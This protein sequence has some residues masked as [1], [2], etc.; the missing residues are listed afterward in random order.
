[1]DRHTTRSAGLG[2]LVGLGLLLSS[3]AIAQ[4]VAEPEQLRMLGRCSG[5]VVEGLDLSGRRLTGVDLSESTIRDVDFSGANLNIALF[6]DATLEN[7]SFASANL[8]GASFVGARLINVSFENT[9]LKA[10]VF[11][12]A[13]LEDT[14]LGRGIS[15]NTQLPDDTTDSTECN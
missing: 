2:F 13:I 10:A 7:V 9:I 8:T 15:C 6:D 3:A 1:M 12:A 4:D 11:D 5:C 14:D